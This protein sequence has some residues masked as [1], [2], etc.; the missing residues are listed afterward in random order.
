[1]P[2]PA[3]QRLID[4]ASAQEGWVRLLA[5]GASPE[6]AYAALLV[7]KG[8]AAGTPAEVPPLTD[9]EPRGTTATEAL[10]LTRLYD[11]RGVN[12][13]ATGQRLDFH[14][15]LTVLYG[16]NASGK[17]GYVRI[18]KRVAGVRAAEPVLGDLRASDETTPHA[19]VDY[20][21]GG[22]DASLEWQEDETGLEPLT[23]LSVF[24]TP[25]VSLHVDDDL[26]YV[27]TPADVAV[28]SALHA[29]LGGLKAKLDA[30]VA[31]AKP[32]ANP[33]LAMF[34]RDAVVWPA[35]EA[36][37]ASTS[38]TELKALAGNHAERLATLREHAEALRPDTGKGRLQ[39]ALADSELYGSIAQLASALKAFD[40]AAHAAAAAR[41][42]N[43]EAA[44]EAAV[45][46]A[47]SE[48]DI[49]GANLPSWRAFIAAAEQ[50][51]DDVGE[52]TYP[53]RGDECL[54]C[55]EPLKPAAMKLV[56]RYRAHIKDA[57]QREL[58]AAVA[59]L[60]M[61]RRTL[62]TLPIAQVATLV[63]RRVDAL[64]EVPQLLTRTFTLF[65]LAL[66]LQAAGATDSPELVKTATEVEA[67]ALA[68]RKKAD[69]LVA[70]VK[71]QTGARQQEL[72]AALAEIRTLENRLALQ[73]QLPAM[74]AYVE[75]AK[76]AAHGTQVSQRISSVMRS[77]TEQSKAA[78]EEAL[79]QDFERLFLAECE[80]LKAPKVEV[81]F[82]GR[83]GQAA[84][85]KGLSDEH[86]LSAVL[87]EGEQKVIALADF[88]A[89]AMLRPEAAPIVF[90]DPITSLD[91]ARVAHV[92]D[93]IAH[94]SEQRQVVVFTH[95]AKFAEALLQRVPGAGR[96]QLAARDGTAGYVS[97][98]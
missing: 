90:D 39:A 19:T 7:E 10:V 79:N 82:S 59:D 29:S 65:E 27:F 95:D 66:K 20:T 36:L 5:G 62:E 78:N 88:L 73:G 71:K 47:F 70:S 94:L 14:P 83:K 2:N 12:A 41:V 30:Q 61:R 46:A 6:Q 43:A 55:R 16:E 56:K 87:S 21:L 76:W 50:F 22:R 98:G 11:V 49:P 15:R 86:R 31:E 24:D 42:K 81:G 85:H 74:A 48:D 91:Q 51:L 89:E 57:S 84:R 92:V 32:A 75:K 45:D 28:Y 77:L 68:E 3:R 54:Y 52:K 18:L 35:V 44:R 38:L 23:R 1:M 96:L 33:F 9:A 58:D 64:D 69:A 40:G 97:A 4:W 25:A 53:S 67:G 93:R 26:T 72:D 13:L 80:A 17:S 37:G 8:L 60:A 63:K 34:Q